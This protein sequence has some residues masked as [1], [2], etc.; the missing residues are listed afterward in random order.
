MERVA[1]MCNN[2]VPEQQQSEQQLQEQQQS[3]EQSQLQEQWQ[4]PE[5][6]FEC[7]VCYGDGSTTG[8]VTPLCGHKVCLACY[9]TML[10]GGLGKRTKCPCCRKKYMSY[11]D[12][13][14]LEDDYDGMPALISQSELHD[15][16]VEPAF[17]NQALR[18]NNLI[19]VSA[20]QNAI[21]AIGRPVGAMHYL[22]GESDSTAATAV[23]VAALAA[24]SNDRQIHTL[25][26]I[27]DF[28]HEMNQIQ[29]TSLDQ[30]VEP[31]QR[32]ME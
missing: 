5:D 21:Q 27:A 13:E 24:L 10:L 7:P 17:I 11:E 23:A 6:V 22:Y 18:Y 14:Q 30:A 29:A 19:A 1:R 31:T 9:S 28:I 15:I 26:T 4:E 8:L 16:N 20:E 3:Q 32:Q 25:N 12:Q 2:I